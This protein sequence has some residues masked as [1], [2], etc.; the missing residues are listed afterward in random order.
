VTLAHVLLQNLTRNR[1]RTAL[2][3]VAF[4]LLMGIF[5]LALSL[6]AGLARTAKQ[7]EQQLR[8]GVRHKVSL[9]N[10]LPDGLRRKI[11]ALDPQHERI[12]SVCGMRWFGG[13]V[14]GTQNALTSL[15]SDA[16]TFP[17]VYPD[18]QMT[19]EDIEHWHRAR[20]AAVVGDGAAEQYGWKTGQRVELESVIPPYL[21]LEFQIIKVIPH[22]SPPN[23]V[24]FRRD[25]LVDSLDAAG[26]TGAGCNI[27]WVK[28]TS[29]AALRS[30]QAQID[31]E[32]A[33]SPNETRSEDENAVI[34]G[35]IQ[36][37]GDIPALARTM[38]MVVIFITA[39]VAG[40]TMSMSFRERTCE[41]A[42][43]KAIGFRAW[44]VFSIVLSE[45][46]L[47]ALL[48][49]LLGIVPVCAALLLIPHKYLAKG[50]FSPP[51]LSLTAVFQSLVIGLAVG[52]IAGFWPACCALRLRTTDALR[53][54]A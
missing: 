53:R 13:R 5:V 17:F 22:A 45:S 15:A 39:L 43:F 46:V 42:V 31:A 3:A 19:A 23:V 1:Q 12:L 38:A 52:V 2:T 25:Y 50:S 16:D 48:G 34:A 44:R 20:R 51:E 14:P 29:A 11:E 54:V 6:V 9:T 7:N 33:N 41:L 35:F 26:V 49:S 40:N 37:V 10:L 32:F 47:L 4:A 21:R 24:Y 30:L 36:G 27:F 8:L 28:C 18:A